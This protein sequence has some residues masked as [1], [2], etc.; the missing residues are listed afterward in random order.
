[1]T[2]GLN[3]LRKIR[4]ITGRRAFSAVF[5]TNIRR[6]CPP[7]ILVA[8]PNALANT[9]MGI[10]ISRAVGIAVKR[11]A[12]KRRLREA[13]RQSRLQLP[14]GYDLVVIVRPHAT[15]EVAKYQQL[16]I[17]GLKSLHEIWIKRPPQE[18]GT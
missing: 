11:N 12:I 13:F 6:S 3:Q 7:L 5:E 18:A 14:T 4:R 16:L 17:S 15:L 8:R 2:K 10:A 9:R 1:V